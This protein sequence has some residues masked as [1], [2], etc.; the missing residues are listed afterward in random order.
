MVGKRPDKK[1][2]LRPQMKTLR[3]KSVAAENLSKKY[4][5]VGTKLEFDVTK[6]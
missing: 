2:G 5:S 1:S 4:W 3:H 6:K